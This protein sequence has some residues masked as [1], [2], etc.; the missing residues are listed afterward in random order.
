MWNTSEAL[1]PLPIHSRGPRNT[2]PNAVEGVGSIDKA[3]D[4]LFQLHA[5]AVPQ[6]VTALGRALGVPKSSVHRMLAVLARRGLVEQND[7]GLYTLGVGLIALGLGVL[8]REPVVEAAKPVL[9]AQAHALGETFFLVAARAGRLVVLDK[10]EGTGFLRAAPR[11][12]VEVPAHATAAG[13]LYRA[14][15]PDEVEWKSAGAERF[16]DRMLVDPAA[17]DRAAVSARR[18]GFARNRDEWIPGL[19]V[20]A[21]PVMLGS[22][23]LAVVAMAAATP[24]MRALGDSRAA[25]LV[26]QAADE[27]GARLMGGSPVSHS[28]PRGPSPVPAGGER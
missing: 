21:A 7:R 25:S 4:V 24:R 13:K 23:M 12:G 22:R 16:T 6:G 26:S 8:D 18:R 11:V 5:A 15:A 17:L 14:F 19:S 3:L 9:E 28:S 20:V 27:I 1:K 2:M 10:A